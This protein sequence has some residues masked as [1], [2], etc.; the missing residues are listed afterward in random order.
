MH[1]VVYHSRFGLFNLSQAALRRLHAE[2]VQGIVID[3]STFYAD[4]ICRHDPRLVAVV[5][6]MGERAGSDL[7][8]AQTSY[9]AYQIH[10]NDGKEKVCHAQAQGEW[11]FILASEEA[12]AADAKLR[13]DLAEANKEICALKTR[14]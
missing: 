8:I 9:P 10:V 11:I 1:K 7:K 3:D 4:D 6:E 14:L 5:E 13:H 12:A 2:G